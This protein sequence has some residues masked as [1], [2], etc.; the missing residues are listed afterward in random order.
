MI[1]LQ[2]ASGMRP[3]EVVTMRGCD[4]DTTGA[5]WV[6]TP[7]KRKTQHHGHERTIYL[8]PQAKAIVS[9][10]LKPDTQAFL[11]SPAAAER[12][13]REELTQARETPDSCGNK[14]GSN[15]RRLPEKAPGQRYTVRSY[16]RAI[17]C[18]CDLAFPPPAHLSRQRVPARGRKSAKSTRW[19]VRAE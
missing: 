9:Q 15:R 1:R 4:L 2:L 12:E 5:V 7:Q 10:F 3:G 16:Y 17:I 8:G 13:R 6:Y 18:A 11:F 19:E 14:L